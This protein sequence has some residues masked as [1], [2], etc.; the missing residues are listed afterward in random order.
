VRP[1]NHYL[2]QELLRSVVFV[3]LLVGWLVRSL[4]YSLVCACVRM[5]VNMIVLGPNISKTVGDRGSIPV[6]HQ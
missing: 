6:D 4:V 2:C 1:A 5:F 3:C